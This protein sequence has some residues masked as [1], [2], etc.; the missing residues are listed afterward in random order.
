MGRWSVFLCLNWCFTLIVNQGRCGNVYRRAVRVQICCSSR[1][2]LEWLCII[3]WLHTE[4]K[5]LNW[6]SL[7]IFILSNSA[8]KHIETG[9]ERRDRIHYSCIK[10]MWVFSYKY[11]ASRVLDVRLHV[12][13]FTQYLMGNL[14]I[15]LDFTTKVFTDWW[16]ETRVYER[17]RA[18]NDY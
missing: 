12:F 2:I 17:C 15:C 6:F 9:R 18:G 4:K 14:L 11:W 3:T 13:F 8:V 10:E 7:I 5:L 1:N 16:A